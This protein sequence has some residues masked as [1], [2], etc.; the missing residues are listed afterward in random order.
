M[1]LADQAPRPLTLLD[2]LR[3]AHL[4]ALVDTLQAVL[5]PWAARVETVVHQ[6]VGLQAVAQTPLPMGLLA[7][8]AN[9]LLTIRQSRR[10]RSREAA[11][12]AVA[13]LLVQVALLALVERAEPARS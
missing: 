10:L 5:A 6:Q 7:L 12:A 11:E 9:L 13:V 8:L 2:P 3:L 1:V 4:A